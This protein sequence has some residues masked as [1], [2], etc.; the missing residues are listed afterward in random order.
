MKSGQTTEL[1]SQVALYSILPK[2]ILQYM[3]SVHGVWFEE[4][5]YNLKPVR[6]LNDQFPQIKPIKVKELLEQAWKKVH[7]ALDD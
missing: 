2:E 7:N 5:V 6:F 4:G 1:P 3:I